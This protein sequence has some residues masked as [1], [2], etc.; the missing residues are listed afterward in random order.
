MDSQHRT[1]PLDS[2]LSLT[3]PFH[4]PFREQPAPSVLAAEIVESLEAAL[5]QVPEGGD[6]LGG[7]TSRSS[8]TRRATIVDR[9]AGDATG[10]AEIGQPCD[11]NRSEIGQICDGFAAGNDA[12]LQ[13]DGSFLQRSI[14]CGVGRKD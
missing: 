11:G 8:R 2:A 1:S 12:F 10:D 3:N 6:R 4:R 13:Q 5:E 9:T 7:R 14:G